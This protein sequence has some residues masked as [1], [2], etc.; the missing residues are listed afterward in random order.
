LQVSDAAEAAIADR[1]AKASPKPKPPPNGADDYGDSAPPPGGEG[2]YGAPREASRNTLPVSDFIA[3]SPDHTYVHRATGETWTSTAVNARVMPVKIGG[4]KEDLAANVWL[5]RNDAVE[6][7]TWAPGEPQVI[8]NNLVAEGGFFAKQGARVFNVYKPPY[9]IGATSRQ[10][11]FWRDRLYAL[12]P[13]EAD[14]VERWLAHRARRPG[15][16]INHALVL[17]GK[18]GIGKDALLAPLKIAVGPWNFAE[19][20]PQAVLGNFNE[21]AQSVVL[22]ISEGKDLGDI[23][24]F[25]LLRGDQ[26][27]DRRAARHAQGQSEICAALLRSER[28]RRHHHHQP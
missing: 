22:R 12:W 7:R 9:V 11:G 18:Q 23:D 2:D 19:I 27:A 20:S 28:H 26:D 1:K 3:F 16:K 5:D 6:Q 15:E 14:H 8:E 21:F 24:R 17:G 25:G 4:D 13:D 10:I